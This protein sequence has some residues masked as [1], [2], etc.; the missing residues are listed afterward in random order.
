MAYKDKRVTIN[1][2][3]S[4]DDWGVLER[5]AREKY[6]GQFLSRNK[7]INCVVMDYIGNIKNSEN[8]DIPEG[9]AA[10]GCDEGV[11]AQD[12]SK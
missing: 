2:L 12:D 8:I 10:V 5:V 7:I 9:A 11:Q 6:A 1:M 3:L 4:D